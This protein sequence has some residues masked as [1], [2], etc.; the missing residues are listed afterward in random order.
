VTGIN[1][2]ELML[3]YS[4]SEGISCWIQPSQVNIINPF[5][6]VNGS[7]ATGGLSFIKNCIPFNATSQ[8][9]LFPGEATIDNYIIKKIKS[10]GNKRLRVWQVSLVLSNKIRNYLISPAQSL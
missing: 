7:T 9:E 8:S 6:Q 1:T 10:S 3:E 5:T 4:L 2:L